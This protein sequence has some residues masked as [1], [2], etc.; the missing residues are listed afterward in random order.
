MCTARRWRRCLSLASAA[1]SAV[2][3]RP[4]LKATHSETSGKCGSSCA[5]R[6]SSQR[7]PKLTGPRRAARATAG[8][9]RVFGEYAEAGDLGGA[10][11]AQLI[12]RDGL[13]LV[14][15]A[16]ERGLQTGGQRDRVAVR[17]SQRLLDD[18]IDQA[19][20]L[21]PVRGQVQRIGR[22]FLLVLALP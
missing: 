21:Q 1:S 2:E 18:L 20:L 8:S 3:S 16:H 5:S 13:E 14:Q 6:A 15:V 17:A 10:L 11:G 9:G 4:P 7:G 12:A 22:H 19:K